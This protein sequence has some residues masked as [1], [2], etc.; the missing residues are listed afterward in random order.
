M[1]EKEQIKITLK[2][3]G[4][5][6]KISLP[7]EPE[8]KQQETMPP[9][10]RD[11]PK[12]TAEKVR[13]SLRRNPA[14]AE[15]PPAAKIVREES[16]PAPR[17]EKKTEEQLREDAAEA[18]ALLKI[19]RLEAMAQ[20]ETGSGLERFG[21]TKRKIIFILFLIGIFVTIFLY[22]TSLE[23]GAKAIAEAKNPKGRFG[24]ILPQNNELFNELINDEPPAQQNNNPPPEQPEKAET[25]KVPEIPEPPPK[26]PEETAFETLRELVKKKAPEK[27]ITA[28]LRKFQNE[29]MQ[30]ENFHLQIINYLPATPYHAVCRREYLRWAKENPES[31]L[32]NLICGAYLLK[33]GRAIP[34]LERALL[35]GRNLKLPYQRLI[36]EY[37]ALGQF[38]RA[39][40][41]CSNYLR[42][43]P[44]DADM[45]VKRAL[46]RFDN[47][48]PDKEILEDLKRELITDCPALSETRRMAKLLL[49]LIHAGNNAEARQMLDAVGK[50]PALQDEW[51]LYEIMYALS[52]NQEAP[53]EALKRENLQTARMKLLYH[54]S[55]KE[56]DAAM[57]V[58]AGADSTIYPDFWDTFASWYCRDDGW[59]VNLMKLNVK[60]GDDL[61]RNTMLRLWQGRITLAQAREIMEHV[62]PHEKGVMAFLLSLAAEREGNRIAKRVLERTSQKSLH[63][64]IYSTLFQRYITP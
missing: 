17:E 10:S 16:P 41:V 61:F 13:I 63:R 44:D 37:Y 12:E 15:P 46:I 64:G 4:A 38:S 40:A 42:I 19:R 14:P 9:S 48:E 43:F 27:E 32:P 58:N 6:I 25:E 22:A 56:F 31:Y 29:F 51:A 54:V 2:P 45:H 11:I 5:K 35:A 26:P 30:L 50:D 47:K 36:G 57:H 59:K 24:K 18:E 20:A 55:R 33:G 7:E 52:N 49:Y 3:K 8:E 21:L 28:Q 53:P 62:P 1:A 23:K 39:S 34:Y 60:F